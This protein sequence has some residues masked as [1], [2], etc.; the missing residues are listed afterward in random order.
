MLTTNLRFLTYMYILDTFYLTNKE[1]LNCVRCLICL[2]SCD[3][4]SVEDYGNFLCLWDK[5]KFSGL[6]LLKQLY[7][8]C[9]NPVTSNSLH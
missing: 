1:N 9:G 8:T 5:T 3:K 2:F 7:K 6:Q 4:L